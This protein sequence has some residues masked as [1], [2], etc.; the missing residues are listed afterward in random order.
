MQ[1]AA[2]TAK[3]GKISLWDLEKKANQVSLFILC[4][5][6]EAPHDG[7]IMCGSSQL[8]AGV[9]L[10]VVVEISADVAVLAPAPVEEKK[11]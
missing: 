7:L 3:G 8:R 9:Y 11:T 5:I 10:R 6:I 1:L 4:G 2:D